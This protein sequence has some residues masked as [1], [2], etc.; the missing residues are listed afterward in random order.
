MLHAVDA[1]EE[2]HD[3][4]GAQNHRQLE[5]FLGHRN[6]IRRPGLLE[7]HL[8]QEAQDRDG[9]AD[10]A[11]GK[12]ATFDQMDLALTDFVWAHHLGRTIKVAG[13]Q[14]DLL[15]TGLLHVV[16][17]FANAHVFEHPLA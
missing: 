6:L 2:P 8:V 15:Q 14:R 10:A 9:D 16:G 13:E 7:R 4:L 11:R 12:L 3:L 5:R 17:K 1:L